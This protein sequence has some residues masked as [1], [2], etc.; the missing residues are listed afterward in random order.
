M[1]V[2]A[3]GLVTKR[4]PEI[5]T[6]LQDALISV[7]GN[8]N[9][10][11]S[12]SSVLGVL[13]SVY[14]ASAAEGQDLIQA[15]YSAGDI[16]RAE[17]IVLDNLVSYIGL[18][19]LKGKKSNGFIYFTSTNIPDVIASGTK[20]VSVN[21]DV[22]LTTNVTRIDTS[23][24]YD[25]TLDFTVASSATYTVN[26]NGVAYTYTS[27]GS[28]TKSEIAN[29]LAAA[30]TTPLVVT[31]VAGDFKLKLTSASSGNTL[32]INLITG[33]M[34]V[35]SATKRT[36]AIAENEGAIEFEALSLSRL[37]TPRNGVSVYNLQSFTIGSS[38]E[39]DIELRAR[40]AASTQL[41]G[42]RTEAAIVARVLAIEGVTKATIRDNVLD[43]TDVVTGLPA[44]SFEV[45]VKGG[46]NTDVA[47]AILYTKSA[48]IQT[49][50]NLAVN[51]TDSDGVTRTINF[52]RPEDVIVWVKI[53]YEL[54]DEEVVPSDIENLI[55]E[56]VL[57]YGEGLE[58]GEDVIPTRFLP[59]LYKN[60]SGL[61]KIVVSLATTADE[62]TPPSTY[63]EDTI[64]IGEFEESRFTLSRILTEEI[65]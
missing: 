11:V 42:L 63:S 46:D 54:Y 26:I 48:G 25:V 18:T 37:E 45:V 34:S 51:V 31:A 61:G 23:L 32:A 41:V 58:V 19:R 15:V 39:T 59:N 33:N 20:V 56:Q 53:Q 29:G 4:F 2:T 9:L 1:T 14:A 57:E 13:N 21:R 12:D 50:G 49:Y 60:I 40:H 6:E 17:G 30:I 16:D 65:V 22:A 64:T 62:L 5:L 8:P 52:S 38:R 47:S 35:F 27:D 44:H 3:T 36:A 28:A 7:S 24:C 55:K 43:T 10:D